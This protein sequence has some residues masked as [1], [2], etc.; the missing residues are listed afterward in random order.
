M[1]ASITFCL[2]LCLLA[3]I[4]KFLML[5][6]RSECS[7]ETHYCTGKSNCNQ[8]LLTTLLSLL[9]MGLC[10]SHCSYVFLEKEHPTKLKAVAGYR[11][12]LF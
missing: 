4:A 3:G 12:L 9:L 8:Q 1:P 7:L 5:P 6:G 10:H 11:C 2:C